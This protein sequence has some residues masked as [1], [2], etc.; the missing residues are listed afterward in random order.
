MKLLVIGRSYPEVET[1]MVGIFEYEQAKSVLKNSENTIKVLYTFCDNRSVLRLRKCRSITRYD[2]GIFTK[3]VYF[4]IGGSPQKIFEKIKTKMCINMVRRLINK[5]GKPNIIHIHF[6]IITLTHGFWDYLQSLEVSIVITEHYSRVQN[7]ELT[8]HQVDLLRKISLGADKFICVNNI[9]PQ[10]IKE[11]TKVNR[12]FLEIPNVVSKNFVFENNK[13]K[14]NGTYHFISI[15]RL[16]KGKKFDLL[17]D[18]F[19][20]KFKDIDNVELIIVGG[21][22]EY[23]N[24]NK[25]INSLGM[26]GRIKL[27]GFLNR[28]ETA[29][30]LEGC[31]SYVTA[32]A[33]ETFGVPV[34]EAMSCGKPIIVANNSPLK[35][36]IQGK[37]GLMF[38]VNNVT[39]LANKMEEMYNKDPII[40]SKKI[41]DL[42]FKYFSEEAVGKKLFSI[43][44]SCFN[45]KKQVSEG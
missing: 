44:R 38:E 3:G 33:F 12:E 1:G 27:T 39:S 25:K 41:A 35:Q 17:I 5:E 6:P 26:E 18:A 11:L 32:S 2:D 29:L 19:Y 30:L 4:P 15:G 13:D 20:Q 37:S 10:S 7:K 23:K 36:Y 43:Y 28:D 9:L 8:N 14:E 22:E 45:D 42:A 31:N 24:L 40:N 34:I 16:V 21:G